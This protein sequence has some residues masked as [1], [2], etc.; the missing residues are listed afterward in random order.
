MPRKS[1]ARRPPRP[2]T[3]PADERRDDLMA[4]A[5]RL[6]ITRGIAATTIDHIAA[7][8]GVAKGTF[9]LYFAAKEDVLAALRARFV[10][11]FRERIAAAVDACAADDWAARLA[12][13]IEAGVRGYLDAVALHDVVFHG[14]HIDRSAVKLADPV[15]DHLAA[16]LAAGTR[17]GA[18][19]VAD[20]RLTA[21]VMF[22]GLHGA[23]DD[24]VGRGQRTDGRALARALADLFSGVAGARPRTRPSTR[25]STRS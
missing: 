20:S 7:R 23:V 8:A 24:A 14:V 15:V 19:R 10:A 11:R 4:A 16:L 2:R 18:W 17:A 22:H 21:L 13:W 1:T 3:K 12:A 6:F 5:E 9:Y 25:Q